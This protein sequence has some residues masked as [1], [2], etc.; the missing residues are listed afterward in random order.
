MTNTLKPY[1]LL[2]PEIYFLNHGSFGACPRPVLEAQQNWQR[3]LEKRPVEFL[4]RRHNDLM[5]E[6][7]QALAN[8]INCAPDEIAYFPNPTTAI[9]MV[10]RNLKLGPGDEVLTSDHEYGAMDRTWRFYSKRKGFTYVRQEIPI[11][12]TTP[13]EFITQF[14]NGVTENTKVIFISQITSQTALIFPV[15]EICKKARQVGIMCIVDGAHAPAQIPVDMQDIQADIYTGA[16]HKWLCAPKGT[17]FIYI[18]KELQAQFEPLVISWG[19]EAETPSPSQFIDYNEWQ[20]TN[21]FS[22]YLTVPKAIE[23]QKEHN[24]DQVRQDC[25]KLILECKKQL[26]ALG[27]QSIVTGNEQPWLMQ[28][29]AMQL[30]GLDPAQLQAMLYQQYKIEIPVYLW[31]ERPYLRVSIQGYNKIADIEALT[32]ALQQLLPKLTKG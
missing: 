29:V 17:A 26:T 19:Y 4:V 27:L 23:F 6:A 1:F 15:K 5:A 7:R 12:V 32:H 24:W 13:A 16:C 10:V 30:P 18:K 25:H 14:W 31:Q 21:D 8:Y 20:G 11:P 9:N 2:D 3:E 28:M 22:A